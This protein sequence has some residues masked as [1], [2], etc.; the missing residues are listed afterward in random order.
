MKTSKRVVL[1]YS[2]AFKQE[3]V[4]SV[5]EGKYTMAEARKVYG[6]PGVSTVRFWMIGMGKLSLLPKM[7]RVEKPDERDRIKELERQVRELKESLA[8]TQVLYLIEKSRFEVVCEEQ[9]L[10]PEEVKKK[11]KAKPSSKQ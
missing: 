11:L 7:I 3:V 1:R 6:I 5:E 10:D 2:E 9:G 8:D 4:K